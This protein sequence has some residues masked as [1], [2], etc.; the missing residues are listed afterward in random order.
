M[1]II[2]NFQLDEKDTGSMPVQIALITARIKELTGHLQVNKK[3]FSCKKTLLML[4]ARRRK[5]LRYLKQENFAQF[6]SIV[7]QLF[8]KV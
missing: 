4:V 8:L 2:K 7:S 6:E 1:E 3:D 5:Y